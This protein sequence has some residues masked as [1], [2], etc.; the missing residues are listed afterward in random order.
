[1]YEN[2]QNQ[3]GYY[4]DGT[5]SISSYSS[6]IVSTELICSKQQLNKR[7]AVWAISIVC[8]LVF[9]GGMFWAG[10]AAKSWLSAQPQMMVSNRQKAEEETVSSSDREKFTFALAY[11]ANY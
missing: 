4:Y 6:E 1:M 7:I 9:A 10:W 11:Q 5:S 3:Y 2:G 8:A